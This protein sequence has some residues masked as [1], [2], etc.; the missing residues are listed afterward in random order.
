MKTYQT[1]AILAASLAFSSVSAAPLSQEN[2]HFA[3]HPTPLNLPAPSISGK[4]VVVE[5]FSYGCNHC[6]N[7]NPHFMSWASKNP[8]V[9][10]QK[11]P[12]GF[13]KQWVPLQKLYYTLDIMGLEQKMGP[14]V[15]DALHKH[16]Q[17]LY[18]DAEVISWASTNGLD[19][20]KFVATYNSMGVQAKVNRAVALTKEYKVGGVPYVSVAGKYHVLN[21]GVQ[22]AQHFMSIVDDLVKRNT[23]TK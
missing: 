22:S 12:V 18:S 5:F 7:F 6:A 13:H 2:V 3:K 23:Q 17:S 19:S 11:V 16:K 9:E 15:F 4:T 8:N 14:A 1:L 21:G 10:I 20:A